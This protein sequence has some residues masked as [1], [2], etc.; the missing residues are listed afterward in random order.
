MI[1]LNTGKLG[2]PVFNTKESPYFIIG[3]IFSVCYIPI[4]DTIMRYDIPAD[5]CSLPTDVKAAVLKSAENALLEK[6]EVFFD[7]HQFTNQDELVSYTI[8]HCK[9]N[10]A[11]WPG[12]M[13]IDN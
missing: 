10:E 2:Q 11:D 12:E 7:G 3:I 5:F 1:I 8:E 4:T 9:S 13:V 6:K